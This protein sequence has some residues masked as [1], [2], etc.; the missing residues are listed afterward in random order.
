MPAGNVPSGH[1][2]SGKNSAISVGGSFLSWANWDANYEGRDLDVTNFESNGFDEGIIGIV[3]LTWNLS[4]SWNAAQSPYTTPPI[5]FP[6]DQGQNMAMYPFFADG[7]A[8]YNMPQYRCL[9]GHGTTKT[10]GTVEFSANGK[11]Q[12]TFTVPMT[13]F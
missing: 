3:S 13:T 8:N 7:A 2:R 1:F 9:S 10:D 12:G 6:S 11:S 4:G 5:L